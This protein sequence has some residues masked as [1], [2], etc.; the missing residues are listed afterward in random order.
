M[1][2]MEENTTSS[3]SDFS[4]TSVTVWYKC[5]ECFGYFHSIPVLRYHYWT[6]H[7]IRS[8]PR[9]NAKLPPGA[10]QGK[11]YTTYQH[12]KPPP[13][14]MRNIE[15]AST[16]PAS[17]P[18]DV[19]NV[20][21]IDVEAPVLQEQPVPSP[22]DSGIQL[23]DGGS[24]T[25]EEDLQQQQLTGQS[26]NICSGK[27]THKTESKATSNEK[28]NTSNITQDSNSCTFCKKK[29][30]SLSILNF[31]LRKEHP[32]QAVHDNASSSMTSKTRKVSPPKIVIKITKDAATGNFTTSPT[33]AADFNPANTVSRKRRSSRIASVE[34][35][36]TT[37]HPVRAANTLL[38]VENM[39][40][41]METDVEGKKGNVS[42]D[43][44][45]EDDIETDANSDSST[46]TVPH[47]KKKRSTSP[48]STSSSDWDVNLNPRN[49]KRKNLLTDSDNSDPESVCS[50]PPKKKKPL[51]S[52]NSAPSSSEQRR[53][54]D[55]T[56]E[57]CKLSKKSKDCDIPTTPN[58]DGE[59]VVAVS[60]RK[61]KPE[62]NN[63]NNSLQFNSEKE[64]VTNKRRKQKKQK[65]IGS[66]SIISSSSED[67]NINGKGSRHSS[68]ARSST[69][70]YQ[71]QINSESEKE[72]S[73]VIKSSRKPKKVMKAR[74]YISSSEP[75]DKSEEVGTN[76]G[77]EGDGD[78][79][80]PTKPPVS[81]DIDENPYSPPQLTYYG[82]SDDEEETSVTETANDKNTSGDAD[83]PATIDSDSDDDLFVLVEKKSKNKKGSSVKPLPMSNTVCKICN[84][85]CQSSSVLVHHMKKVH[86]GATMICG[87]CGKRYLNRNP[88]NRHLR[89]CKAK[90]LGVDLT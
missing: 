75:E 20:G 33:S 59:E 25:H 31:H 73:D 22:T 39:K 10:L 51:Q 67:E 38:T 77:E 2:S 90:K 46:A 26:E 18:R 37:L 17:H 80:S 32:H 30:K 6:E 4:I 16:F 41:Y 60:K 70:R 74:S 15:S 13:P 9:T 21:E 49:K 66:K 45:A 86:K 28:E 36:E 65:K 76:Q 69:N 24:E 1:Y 42:E 89:I 68:R 34:T 48:A 11:I 64:S 12:D 78:K 27:S 55:R 19:D 52:K 3:R 79:L 56:P 58:D 62:Q 85:E 47:A 54:P 44:F 82:G 40:A 50:S 8:L 14:P 88:F 84:V 43:I 63:S 29:F 35:S 7:N 5:R 83:I 61:K 53:S 71:N 23:H 57:S 72:T 87:Y 81:D